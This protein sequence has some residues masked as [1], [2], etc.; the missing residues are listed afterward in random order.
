VT[1]LKWVILLPIFAAIVLLAVAN[2]QSV[3]VNL[4]PFDKADSVLRAVL[5]LYQIGFLLFVLGVLFGGVIAWSG[6]RKHRRRLRQD[7]AALWQA[8]AEWSEQRRREAR[9]SEAVAFL[10]RPER[11]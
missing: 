10:P 8:R 5:P 3:T 9:P 4:N 7:Q 6:Q 1:I 11:G 2:D